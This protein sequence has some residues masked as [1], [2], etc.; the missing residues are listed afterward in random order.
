MNKDRGGVTDLLA[1]GKRF[2]RDTPEQRRAALLPFLWETIAKDG[3]VFGSHRTGSVGRV[4]NG[5]NFSYPGYSEVLCG[6][7]DTAVKSN[8]KFY[9]RNATVLEWLHAKPEFAGK[10]AAFTS[11]DV[12]PFI[13]NDKRSGIPVNAGLVPLA[14]V[15]DTPEVRLLN[16]LTAEIPLA[17][18]GTRPDALTFH[19]AMIYLKEKKPRVLFVSFDETDAQAHAGRYD[20]V[21]AGAH[22]ADGFVRELWDTVQAMPEYRGKTTLIVTTDHGR[23]GAPV[24]W[25]NHNAKTKGAEF[26]WAAVLGPDTPPLGERKDTGPVTQDR[27]AATAAAAL[28]YDYRAAV[29]KAGKPLPGAVRAGE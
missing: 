29:P 28:G 11:W 23:G 5:H 15:A 17:G 25:K 2:W 20:R 7:P 3:Q 21:L 26:W 12:F 14:G 27:A 8:A 22:K 16:R 9:N 24:E 19:A 4:T 18:E 1:T 13:I 6:F 10:V